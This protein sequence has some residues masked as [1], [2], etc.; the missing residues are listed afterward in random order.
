MKR[1]HLGAPFCIKAQRAHFFVA[2]QTLASMELCT[3]VAAQLLL[4]AE[5]DS[6]DYK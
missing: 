5:A 2:K 3:N 4:E 6:N 1:P